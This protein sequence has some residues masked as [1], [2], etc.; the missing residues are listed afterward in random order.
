[1]P[2]LFDPQSGGILSGLAN[3]F[4]DIQR[5]A[6]GPAGQEMGFRNKAYQELQQGGDPNAALLMA[7]P[8]AYQMNIGQRNLM[9]TIQALTPQYGHD[10]AVFLAL[11]PE[12]LTESAKPMSVPEGGSV[13]TPN[14]MGS[15]LPQGGPSQAPPQ[16]APQ[17][18]P[19]QG[20]DAAPM[21]G[22]PGA[23]FTNTNGVIQQ[24]ALL[25][26]ARQ[27]LLGKD[28]QSQLGGAMGSRTNKSNF[29]TLMNKVMADPKQFG[30]DSD[31][32][33]PEDLVS[34]QAAFPA[35]EDALKRNA[36]IS[37]RMQLAQTEARGIL[38]LFQQAI[39]KLGPQDYPIFNKANQLWQAETGNPASAEAAS[40]MNALI[41]TYARG[42]AP[43]GGQG[44]GA[45]VNATEHLREVVN[46]Y[47]SKGQLA[48]GGAAVMNEL[49][50]AN[51]AIK[52]N[53]N[54]INVRYGFGKDPAK[55]P[56]P[57]GGR[58]WLDQAKAAAKGGVS[59]EE[60]ERRL[61]EHGFHA[62]GL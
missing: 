19:G 18:A 9:A 26:L 38:P 33:S 20:S 3:F 23:Q 45:T 29:Q 42:V 55:A 15:P 7:N 5:G 35:Y 16:A 32:V 30:I 14:P 17:A 24:P 57:Q 62:K 59:R 1:M 53:G 60:V 21:G 49:N 10:R 36:D 8:A 47:W 41:N 22:V 46:P 51:N 12:I 54:E 6:S 28:V 40:Y 48:A 13:F 56:A 31:P 25:N 61:S 50:I 37:S 2:G 43:S 44:G 27:A 11:H 39:A 34:R 58:T 52:T 4:G